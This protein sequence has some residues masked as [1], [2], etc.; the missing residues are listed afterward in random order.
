MFG[1]YVG[2]TPEGLRSA[3]NAI[4]NVSKVLGENLGIELPR[5]A[6]IGDQSSGKS[7]LLESIF[8]FLLPCEEDIVTST[9]IQVE[10]WHDDASNMPRSA[11]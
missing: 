5:V 7:S 10:H 4:D 11:T 6:V 3:L 8:G 9:P 1:C 2:T